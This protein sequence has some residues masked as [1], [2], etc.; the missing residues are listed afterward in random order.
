MLDLRFCD[1][2]DELV[3]IISD[4]QYIAWHKFA[5]VSYDSWDPDAFWFMDIRNLRNALDRHERRRTPDHQILTAIS[6]SDAWVIRR[7]AKIE[8][9]MGLLG[10][11]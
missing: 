3:E 4:N 7:K 10:K 2:P 6:L 5:A 8:R 9:L 11:N 1:S